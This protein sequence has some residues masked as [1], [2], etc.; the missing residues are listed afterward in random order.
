MKNVKMAGT[1]IYVPKN[2][3]YNQELDQHFE[4]NGFSAGSLV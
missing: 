4:N 1:G 2:K 3:V